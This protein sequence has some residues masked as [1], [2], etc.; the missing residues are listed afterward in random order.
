[1]LNEYLPALEQD[2]RAAVAEATLTLQGP[3]LYAEFLT[4]LRY[5]LGWTDAQGQW[6][7]A[8]AGKRLRPLLCLLSTEAAGDNAAKE[9]EHGWHDAVPAATAIELVHNFS[10]IHDDIQ[11]NSAERRGRAAL[12]TIWG[13]AQ[14][15]N[16]GDAMFVLA[17][18]AL[19]R[20]QNHVTPST[21]AA[22]HQIFDAA[23][24]ALTQ[25]QF[26]D[27]CF[28]NRV[29]VTIE[30]YFSMVRGKTAALLAASAEIGAR[31]AI[32]EA[33]VVSALASYGENLGIAFQIVD[34]ILGIWGDPA[35]TGKSAA[36]DILAKKKSLPIL[37]AWQA[38][39]SSELAALFTEPALTNKTVERTLQILSRTQARD[40][41]QAQADQYLNY[42]L[43]ALEASG[44]DNAATEQLRE[45]A[46]N[47]TRR[48][49]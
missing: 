4:M 46:Y 40:S 9:I 26:L 43:R 8:D 21:F 12:W 2:L 29:D 36:S 35:V 11:D 14:G 28:E 44:R 16:A 31:I 39:A 45:L 17:R 3:R 22:V 18:L 27:I 37:I 42:A 23:T 25:G 48:N 20:L 38:D 1:M 34:D 15:I 19:D 47:A 32:D 5:H 13:M 49:K 10:L 7:S 30:E 24:L 41:A 33:Q 6:L